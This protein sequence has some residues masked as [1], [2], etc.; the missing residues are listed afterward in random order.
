[1]REEKLQRNKLR[2][3]LFGDSLGAVIDP[4]LQNIEIFRFLSFANCVHMKSVYD[5]P[6][7]VL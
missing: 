3:R 7:T 6:H 4:D 5:I 1:M 2:R